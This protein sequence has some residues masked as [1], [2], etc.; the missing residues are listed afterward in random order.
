[1][2]RK[3]NSAFTLVELIVVITILAILWTIA[4]ISLQWY[5]K[6][7][8]DS[9]RISDISNIKTSLELFMLK[10]WYY[11]LPDVV[12]TW[13]V[14]YSW[15]LLWTQ[16]T[17]WDNVTTNLS[18]NLTNKPTDPLL[19]I[20]YT[21]SVSNT[22]KEYQ[23]MALYEWELS[24]TNNL[25]NSSYA[26]NSDYKIK[27]E[28]IYNEIFLKTSKYIVPVPSIITSEDLPFDLQV[29]AEKIQSMVLT[30]WTNMP[31]IW[32]S[33]ITTQ[34]WWINNITLTTALTITSDSW[35]WAKIAVIDV[36]QATYSWT[37]LA[38]QSIYKNILDKTSDTDKLE[39]VNYVVLNK[40]TPVASTTT[41]YSCT[42]TVPSSNV[43]KTNNTWLTV[44][45]DWQNTQSLDDCYYECT[46]GYTGANCEI[47][48]ALITSTDCTDANWLWV[49][50]ATDNQWNWF[51]ISPRVEWWTKYIS[52]M[53]IW[54]IYW[55]TRTNESPLTAANSY[56]DNSYWVTYDLWTYSCKSLW[57]SVLW[58]TLSDW[59]NSNLSDNP[60]S[61]L[62]VDDTIVNRMRYL[63]KYKTDSTKIDD[64]NIDWITVPLIPAWFSVPA[65]YLSDCI[66]WT[67]DL[68]DNG[69]KTFD[70]I[71]YATY[72]DTTTN[73]DASRILRNRYL[74][75]WT[76]EV[77]SHLP[78]AYSD[79]FS[80]I[81]NFL[82]INKWEYQT[83]CEAGKFW[84]VTWWSNQYTWW[85][86]DTANERIWLSAVGTPTGTNWGRHA[87]VVGYNGC[88]AQ[89]THFAGGRGSSVSARFVVRP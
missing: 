45:T 34:T 27:V 47:E 46:W 80:E 36:I 81:T 53:D 25:L 15:E 86:D 5:S 60:D 69:W 50:S 74:L 58:L 79:I 73:T 56:A 44:D 21:Y 48:P 35:T 70:S 75:W 11:P 13:T 10:T 49:D 68:A 14:S 17:V 83:A 65:L 71:N 41:T 24:K 76:K 7:A 8:R 1:M 54:T 51:C 32:A 62:A 40:P 37:T 43:T 42:W 4:F 84:A 78:S 89:L 82:T 87:R 67:R 19:D 85:E 26:A 59:D 23:V 29:D 30:N 33:W 28:W 38:N 3:T 63:A 6:T 12:W 16:W 2:K 9:R 88:G 55:W 57:T 72:S 66:D 20:E 52:W 18:R 31:N 39:L 61:T 77:W 64:V 22:K